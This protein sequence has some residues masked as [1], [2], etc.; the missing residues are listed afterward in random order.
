[1]GE[2]TARCK[3]CGAELKGRD[4]YEGKCSSCREKEI[5][6]GAGVTAEPSTETIPPKLKCPKCGKRLPKRGQFCHECG[7]DLYAIGFR[8][9]SSNWPYVVL[10][11]AIVATVYVLIRLRPPAAR[12]TPWQEEV[13]TA[14]TQLLQLARDKKFDRI[15]SLY[16]AESV[17]PD[18]YQ[19][20]RQELLDL[21]GHPNCYLAASESTPYERLRDLAS[22]VSQYPDYCAFLVQNM[23]DTKGRFRQ[24]AGRT[25]RYFEWWL[26]MTFSKT[27]LSSPQ[28]KIEVPEDKDNQEA[29]A[30]IHYSASAAVPGFDDPTEIKWQKV[31][32]K[33]LPLLA[34]DTHL[35]DVKDLLDKLQR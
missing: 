29:T 24:A 35:K 12:L 14:T 11:V 33:L 32:G 4:V 7:Q 17:N 30:K 10:V 5:L 13:L 28:I 1:M 20:L 27:D 16:L 26:E 3:S 18:R 9:P 25:D 6:Y 22:T 8:H 21:S 23:A 34:T 2:K 19:A 15:V 31:E